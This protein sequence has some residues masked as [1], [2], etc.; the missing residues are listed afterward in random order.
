ME[1]PQLLVTFLN[2]SISGLIP[3]FSF[4]SDAYFTI[5][6]SLALIKIHL[7][8]SLSFYNSLKFNDLLLICAIFIHYLFIKFKLLNESILFP[9][10]FLLRQ[11]FKIRLAP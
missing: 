10:K 6:A 8:V 2:K 9:H 7:R 3:H 11:M 4:K 1:G 5:N